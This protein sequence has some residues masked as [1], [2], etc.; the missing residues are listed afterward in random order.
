MKAVIKKPVMLS[1]ILLAILTGGM[2]V[3]LQL[4]LGKDLLP[5]IMKVVLEYIGSFGA[6]LMI[7]CILSYLLPLFSSIL[8]NSITDHGRNLNNL[9]YEAFRTNGKSEALRKNGKDRDVNPIYYRLAK[10]YLYTP[11]IGM[12]KVMAIK[13]LQINIVFVSIFYAV[14]IFN[15]NI[16]GFDPMS[17]YRRCIIFFISIAY[18]LM[19]IGGTVTR[20]TSLHDELRSGQARAVRDEYSDYKNEHIDYMDEAK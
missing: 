3:I 2:E 8:Y 1:I 16:D 9:S 12:P 11:P 17:I 18:S 14:L 20:P 13:V 19:I 7:Y 6:G 4:D 10:L 5:S 15:L